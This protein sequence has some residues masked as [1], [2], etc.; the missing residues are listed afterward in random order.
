[1]GKIV[2]AGWPESIGRDTPTRRLRKVVISAALPHPNILAIHDFGGHGDIS[3]AVMEFLEGTTLRERLS[4]GT[5][6]PTFTLAG[7]GLHFA[8]PR[9]WA[10]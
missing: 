9:V 2:A 4:G 3:Y 7:I 10:R 8:C 1:M 5:L 6:D